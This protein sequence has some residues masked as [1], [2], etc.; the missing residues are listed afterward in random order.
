MYLLWPWSLPIAHH[1]K[2]RIHLSILGVIHISEYIIESQVNH[3]VKNL[4]NSKSILALVITCYLLDQLKGP[5]KEGKLS[6]S[7]KTLY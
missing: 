2:T 5:K 3:V 1:L 4:K 6:S 7:P